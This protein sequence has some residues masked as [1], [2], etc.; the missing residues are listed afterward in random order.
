MVVSPKSF[1][2]DKNKLVLLTK[3]LFFLA[4]ISFNSANFLVFDSFP[5]FCRITKGLSSAQTKFSEETT[6]NKNNECST[7]ISLLLTSSFFSKLVN[8]SFVEIH[9]LS[10]ETVIFLIISHSYSLLSN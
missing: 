2:F 8:N 6:F 7:L 9:F 4:K 1:I 3:D 5:S 10:P